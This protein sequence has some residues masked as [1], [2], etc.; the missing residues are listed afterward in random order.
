LDARVVLADLS[1]EVID[2]L[3]V[4]LVDQT[5]VRHDGILSHHSGDDQRKTVLAPLTASRIA[6]HQLE[7]L[8]DGQPLE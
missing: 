2:M 5:V 6:R 4:R 8:I 3:T 1:P 7:Q